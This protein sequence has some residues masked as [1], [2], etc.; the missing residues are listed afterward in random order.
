MY[1]VRKPWYELNNETV[2][3][4]LDGIFLWSNV[5]HEA[6]RFEYKSNAEGISELY[7]GE[8]YEVESKEN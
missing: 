8:V 3:K 7:G 2:Y 6:R 4:Y 5:I 1:I